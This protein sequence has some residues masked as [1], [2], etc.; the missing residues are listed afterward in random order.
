MH[1]LMLNQCKLLTTRWRF[2]RRG[3]AS[4]L[5]E[6]TLADVC[7]RRHEFVVGSQRAGVYGA[8]ANGNRAI[9]RQTD[10]QTDGMMN[11]QI[12]RKATMPLPSRGSASKPRQTDK[13]TDTQTD[14][15]GATSSDFLRLFR[16]FCLQAPT[17]RQTDRRTSYR[18]TQTDRQTDRHTH[19]HHTHTQTWC[20]LFHLEPRFPQVVEELLSPGLD[21]LLLRH[22]LL[23]DLLRFVPPIGERLPLHQLHVLLIRQHEV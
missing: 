7:S 18:Q 23:V 14:R 2:E 11:R 8:T 3:T 21:L 5:M 1:V 9:D 19:R 20:Y 22:A 12:L 13:Q 17:D 4:L 10:R 15:Q 16:N 6:E